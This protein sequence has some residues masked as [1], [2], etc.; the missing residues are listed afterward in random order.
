L[1]AISI[2]GARIEN[3]ADCRQFRI[4]AVSMIP[5]AIVDLLFFFGHQDEPL[6]DQPPA[7]SAS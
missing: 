3:S 1:F 4:S 5:A 7:R 6:G 2:V